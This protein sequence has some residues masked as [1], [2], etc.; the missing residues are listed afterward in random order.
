[1]TYQYLKRSGHKKVISYM[2]H[3]ERTEKDDCLPFPL[4]KE[5]LKANAHGL[6]KNMMNE[7]VKGYIYC[8]SREGSAL[9]T[10]EGYRGFMHHNERQSEPRLGEF[11]E[12]RGID[13]KEDGTINVSLRPLKQESMDKDAEMIL[14][15]LNENDGV[16]PFSDKSDP[17]DIQGTYNISKGAFKR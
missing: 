15:S 7:K 17:E 5:L 4:Q 8:T 2:S 14:T 9:F 16:I 10:D 3:L 6:P 1:M 13:V 11:V 12:G